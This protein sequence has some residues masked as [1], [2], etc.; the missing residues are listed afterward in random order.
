MPLPALCY[1]AK[2]MIRPIRNAKQILHAIPHEL[3]I[4]RNVTAS[5]LNSWEEVPDAILCFIKG[6]F[7]CPFLSWLPAISLILLSTIF[8]P[9][10]QTPTTTTT[11]N[12]RSHFTPVLNVP[13]IHL[14]SSTA[15]PSCPSP[16]PTIIS[17][18]LL[19]PNLAT[20]HSV[21]LIIFRCHHRHVRRTVRMA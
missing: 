11:G 3:I 18:P 8:F 14:L 21:A 15:P 19:R 12:Q 20:I 4:L 1:F 16:L 13:F 6:P 5:Y 7:I 2:R 9:Q 10:S 17:P